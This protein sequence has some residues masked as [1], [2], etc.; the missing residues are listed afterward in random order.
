MLALGGLLTSLQDQLP[1][2]RCQVSGVVRGRCHRSRNNSEICQGLV[3]EAVKCCSVQG[4]QRCGAGT[5]VNPSQSP[6]TP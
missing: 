3:G 5:Q 1:V 6:E 4:T 2:D